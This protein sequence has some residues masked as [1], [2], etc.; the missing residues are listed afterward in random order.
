MECISSARLIGASHVAS[1]YRDRACLNAL[2]RN[3]CDDQYEIRS[4]SSACASRSA[5]FPDQMMRLV[6][7]SGLVFEKKGDLVAIRRNHCGED[8]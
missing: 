5:R 7:V 4:I 1:N 2:I 3:Y 6:N 8:A